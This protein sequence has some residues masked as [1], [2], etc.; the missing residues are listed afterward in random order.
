VEI[1]GKIDIQ[2]QDMG[3]QQLKNIEQAV[4]VYRVLLDNAVSNRKPSP[5]LPDR[6]SIAVLPFQNLS[7]DSDADYFA[8]G[9]VEE[10]IIALSQ[11]SSPF[12]IARNSSFTY[13]GRNVDAK[14][15]GRE[16][17]VRYLLEA[18]C[19]EREIACDLQG[20]LSRLPMGC[21]FGPNASM[22]P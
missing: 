2:C 21:I 16:L 8:D 3:Q 22:A 13:K 6:P 18:V 15:I 19:A 7:G 20:N 9:M 14:Q 4:R 5:A 11:F 10:I 12:V 17:G 1:A